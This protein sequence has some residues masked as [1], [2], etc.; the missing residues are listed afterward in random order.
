MPRSKTNPKP[1]VLK[2]TERT[3]QRLTG[4][5]ANFIRSLT[6]YQWAQLVKDRNGGKIMHYGSLHESSEYV[7]AEDV[8]KWTDE[9]IEPRW[10][11]R[12][13]NRLRKR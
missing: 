10:W 13:I 2:R 3:V 9:V 4:H 6:S 1:L 7:T 5:T 12:L 8:K 11:Y